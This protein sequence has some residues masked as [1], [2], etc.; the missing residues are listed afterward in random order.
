[1]IERISMFESRSQLSVVELPGVERSPRCLFAVCV[2]PR[3]SRATNLAPP[4]TCLATLTSPRFP[5]QFVPTHDRTSSSTGSRSVFGGSVRRIS[6]ARH[7]AAWLRP[8]VIFSPASIWSTRRWC[9]L[10]EPFSCGNSG[11]GFGRL[12]STLTIAS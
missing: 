1:M 11:A 5:P 3:R 9:S 8:S 12:S 10:L 6:T 2:S 4:L 7:H